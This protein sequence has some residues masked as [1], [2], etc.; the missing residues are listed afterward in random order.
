MSF[1]NISI[2]AAN[3]IPL[4]AG[5]RYDDNIDFKATLHQYDDGYTFFHQP[6]FN[7]TKDVKFANE[8]FFSITSASVLDSLISDLKYI[9]PTELVFYTSLKAANNY[10]VTNVGNSL[11]AT[12]TA[13]TPS[14]F[15]R[16]TRN[17]D[18]TCSISQNNLYATIQ[19][20]NNDFSLKM[21]TKIESDSDNLQKFIF[22]TA[23][24]EDIFSIKTSFRMS[25]WSPYITKPV[26]R[27]LSFEDNDG[28]NKIKA[29]G[30]IN[31]TSY[32]IENNYKF[33]TTLN[34]NAF[35]I[36]FDGKVVWVKY[37]NEVLHKFF[38]KTTDI[39]DIIENV[40][41]NYL[42][43]YPYKTEIDNI[44]PITKTGRMNIN[45]ITLKNILTPEYQ[46]MVKKE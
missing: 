15:F 45:L 30:L 41:N 28:T 38:N 22:Y 46:Y 9:N 24:N 39:S 18:G 16:I 32:P 43:E 4:S 1:S 3:I 21:V 8:S 11:Y 35:A 2:S 42:I 27:F 34:L 6:I 37:F 5:Y 40:R 19:T 25:E 44:N 26:E 14:E 10:Y 31:N 33:Y 23:D 20:E 17:T 7:G 13:V 36:G 29:I 12:A